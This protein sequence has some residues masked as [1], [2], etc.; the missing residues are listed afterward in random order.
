LFL[1]HQPSLAVHLLTRALAGTCILQETLSHENYK[2]HKSYETY[3]QSQ[4]KAFTLLTPVKHSIPFFMGLSCFVAA[5][6]SVSLSGAGVLITAL[7]LLISDPR[8]KDRLWRATGLMSML[9]AA[10]SF[11][12]QF[13]WLNKLATAGAF[14]YGLK[15]PQ[16]AVPNPFSDATSGVDVADMESS[17][18]GFTTTLWLAAIYGFVAGNIHHEKRRRRRMEAAAKG[19]SGGVEMVDLTVEVDGEYR[20]SSDDEFFD[21]EAEREVEERRASLRRATLG[22]SGRSERS[23]S[24]VADTL[25]TQF[26]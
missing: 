13:P 14:W 9:F 10:T 24:A 7:V 26:K 5:L 18:L 25:N 8:V 12:F 6:R 15:R 17:I 21:A 22:A 16:K 20:D 11:A 2:T 4:I 3:W 23:T 1:S 19:G